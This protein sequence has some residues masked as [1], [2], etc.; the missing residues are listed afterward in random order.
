M[1]S[2]LAVKSIDGVHRRSRKLVLPAAE[3]RSERFINIFA[4]MGYYC[5]RIPSKSTFFLKIGPTFV[6]SKDVADIVR[7][8]TCNI[9]CHLVSKSCNNRPSKRM[10]SSTFWVNHTHNLSYSWKVRAITGWSHAKIAVVMVPLLVLVEIWVIVDFV[11]SKIKIMVTQTGGYSQT[12]DGRRF[13]PK[14]KKCC[15]CVSELV[16]LRVAVGANM[17]VCLHRDFHSVCCK[18]VHKV[19]EILIDL[20]T[21]VSICATEVRRHRLVSNRFGCVVS[22]VFFVQRNIPRYLSNNPPIMNT[23]SSFDFV[24][25]QE[26]AQQLEKQYLRCIGTV[27]R[28]SEHFCWNS[29]KHGKQYNVFSLGALC[30]AHNGFIPECW[31]NNPKHR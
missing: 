24:G 4:H 12:T 31:P 15:V 26:G 17:S 2:T 13:R 10:C 3:M 18:I 19:T 21:A 27:S 16:V 9:F 6:G 1:H 22:G 28:C 11:S 29:H 20:P 23:Y 5:D 30:V 8:P 25:F 7:I 14:H